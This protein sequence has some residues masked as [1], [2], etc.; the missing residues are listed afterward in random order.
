MTAII[1]DWVQL[2]VRKR[3]PCM[4]TCFSTRIMEYMLDALKPK[5]YPSQIILYDFLTC[6]KPVVNFVTP[7][8]AGML[9]Q[10][11]SKLVTTPTPPP[12]LHSSYAHAT[13]IFP[14]DPSANFRRTSN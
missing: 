4:K 11:S 9:C 6:N 14:G 3:D 12:G 13:V 8:H 2:K 10:I 5:Y 7:A 1:V